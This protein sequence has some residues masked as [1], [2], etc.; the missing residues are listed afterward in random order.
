MNQWRCTTRYFSGQG[1]GVGE[2]S[3]RNW[4]TLIKNSVKNTRKKGP[5]VKHFG[6]FFLD[7]LKTIFWMGNLTQ[8]WTQSRIFFTKIFRY[9]K[10]QGRSPLPFSCAPVSATEYASISLNMPKYPWKCLKKLFWLCQGSIY[11]WSSDMLHKL[12]KMFWVLNQPE[13]WIWHCCICKGYTEFRIGLIMSP[14]V[15]IMSDCVWI[16]LETPQYASTWLNI[17]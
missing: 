9:Q 6:V 7:S 8:R 17:A 3:W 12:L 5:T 16:C 1:M 13:F 10:R 11:A 2:K 14:Y 4:G 15:L